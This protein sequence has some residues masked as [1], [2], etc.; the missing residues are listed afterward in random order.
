MRVHAIGYQSIERPN[1]RVKAYGTTKVNFSMS[2]KYPTRARPLKNW[3]D[4]VR[5]GPGSA[6][7]LNA[8]VIWAQG[9][10]VYLAS[11][12]SLWL[13][14]GAGLRFH[15][16]GREVATA[17]VT[18]VHNAILIAARITSG[19]LKSVRRLDRMKVT[20]ERDIVKPMPALRVGYPSHRRIHPLFECSQ[21]QLNVNSY[22][23]DTLGELSYRLVRDS[24]WVPPRPE[25]DTL[26]IR[27]F[28][29]VADEEIAL[30]RGDLD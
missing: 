28:D 18:A 27:L 21:M 1:V 2:P 25:P 3:G 19:S 13:G 24:T 17:E 12:D 29:D 14:S 15:D 7:A 26:H 20:S 22:R 4:P 23:A 9:D 10:R 6:G 8:R 16:N 5:A 30:E 11:H